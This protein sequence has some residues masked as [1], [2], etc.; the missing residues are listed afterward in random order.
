MTEQLNADTASMAELS[1]EAMDPIRQGPRLPEHPRW[2]GRWICRPQGPDHRRG[3]PP[4]PAGAQRSDRARAGAQRTTKLISAPGLSGAEAEVATPE[5]ASLAQT[6]V[7]APPQ[8][9]QDA[10]VDD[11]QPRPEVGTTSAPWSQPSE[12]GVTGADARP[13]SPDSP[14]PPDAQA[15]TDAIPE[16]PRD[17]VENVAGAAAPAKRNEV[18]AEAPV[19]NLVARVLGV[20]TDKRNWR[21]APRARRR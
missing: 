8:P 1:R 7:W 10:P 17:L 16:E 13:G 20:K 2:C 4:L 12:D 11:P 15:D 21:V 3:G 5:P 9:P 18:N 6:S 14:E 19:S